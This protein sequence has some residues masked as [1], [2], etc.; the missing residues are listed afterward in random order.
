MIDNFYVGLLS[1]IFIEKCSFQAACQF[2]AKSGA[3]HQVTLGDQPVHEINL[4]ATH[5]LFQFFSCISL[6]IGIL[7]ILPQVLCSLPL[8]KDSLSL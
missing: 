1:G 5:G 8:L 3:I 7:N 6:L 4:L 2:N